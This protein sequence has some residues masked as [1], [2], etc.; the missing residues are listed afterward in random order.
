M[1]FPCKPG[2]L[3]GPEAL[4]GFLCRTVS[5]RRGRKESGETCYLPCCSLNDPWVDTP[6]TSKQG[7]EG[8]EKTDVSRHCS[9]SLAFGQQQTLSSND[10]AC[11]TL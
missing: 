10:T 1:S 6:C 4:T 9:R 11:K 2:F 3:L 5:R 7:D 8:H